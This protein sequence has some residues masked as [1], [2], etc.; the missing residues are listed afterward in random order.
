M[1]ALLLLLA[2]AATPAADPTTAALRHCLD[3]PDNASTGGQSECE[4]VAEKAYDQRMNRAYATLIRALPAPAADRLRQSQRSWLAFRDAEAQA[5]T[6]LYE[7]R[8]G[9][10]YVP[11]EANDETI[12]T[13]DRALQLEGYVRMIHI[14]P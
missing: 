5:R 3:Q 1:K 13:R 6:A 4:T 14:E 2:T 10:M 8:H 12:V 9:T 11:M 7:T